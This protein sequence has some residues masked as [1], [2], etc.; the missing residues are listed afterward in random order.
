MAPTQSKS[1]YRNAK[2]GHG[3]PIQFRFLFRYGA[4]NEHWTLQVVKHGRCSNPPPSPQKRTSES[5]IRKNRRYRDA[6]SGIGIWIQ[7]P[8]YCPSDFLTVWWEM[9]P[10]IGG[11][12]RNKC[13]PLSAQNLNQ[14][15]PQKI[16]QNLHFSTR[17][18]Q[19]EI[20][21]LVAD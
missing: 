10:Q 14:K 19:L 8:L 16:N 1:E 17:G 5:E 3:S 13:R 15:Q 7:Y 18:S 9:T 2:T 20:L 4:Q 11:Q 6:D 12:R 21:L